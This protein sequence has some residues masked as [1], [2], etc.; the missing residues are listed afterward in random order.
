MC[1]MIEIKRT[2]EFLKRLRVLRL[3]IWTTYEIEAHDLRPNLI[4]TT[5]SLNRA[6]TF[7]KRY[8]RQLEQQLTSSENPKNKN[9]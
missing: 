7:L 5:K 4:K 8:Q 2:K 1:K 9:K 3:D 6:L